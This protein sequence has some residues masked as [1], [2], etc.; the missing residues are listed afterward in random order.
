MYV[1]THIY[2][3]IY[4]CVCVCLCVCME[5]ESRKGPRDARVVCRRRS[6]A[7]KNRVPRTT[8]GRTNT[9]ASRYNHTDATK[10]PNRLIQHHYLRGFGAN[11]SYRR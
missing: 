1:H 9:S 8:G 4:V 11:P 10:Q 5:R 7:N 3:Y 6:A 2:I